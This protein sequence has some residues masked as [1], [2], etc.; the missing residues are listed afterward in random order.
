MFAHG[1]SD[2]RSTANKHMYA[3][4]TTASI[5]V[6]P[7]PP[8]PGG[9]YVPATYLSTNTGFSSLNHQAFPPLGVGQPDAK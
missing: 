7:K 9:G 2:L 1:E 6:P 8:A 4:Q 5:S 3:K